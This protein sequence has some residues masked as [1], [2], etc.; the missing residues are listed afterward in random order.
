MKEIPDIDELLNSFIDGE[1]TARQETQ[2]KRLLA[3]D[4]HASERLRQL[5]KCKIL[6]SS[7][8][9]AEA[10]EA[11]TGQILAKLEKRIPQAHQPEHLEKLK[12][13]RHLLAR[14]VL[15]AAA[16]LGLV[17]IL[18]AVIYTI[19]GPAKIKEKPLAVEQWQPS[20]KKILLEEPALSLTAAEKPSVQTHLA[21][22]QF[23][24]RLELKTSSLIAVEAVLNRTFEDNGLLKY[25]GSISRGNKKLYALSCSRQGLRALLADLE[26]IWA[27]L[28]SATLYVKTDYLDEEIAVKSVRPEQINQIVNQDNPEKCIKVAKD[29]A[30]LNNMTE[31]LEGNGILASLDK[32]KPELVTIPKPI[33]TSSKKSLEKPSEGAEKTVQAHLLIVLIG[34]AE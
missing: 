31:L 6:V 26:N 21:L 33:L 12:G 25:S 4:V 5:R 24:G 32:S 27:R 34:T 23:N 7:L 20:G 13:A 10:P 16:M 11:L 8:P 30:V 28:D 17:A 29:L 9:R 3:H 18:G 1:L 15:A 19:V 14:K 22:T 2:L